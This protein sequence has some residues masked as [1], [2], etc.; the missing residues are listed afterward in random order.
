VR[1]PRGARPTDR[2]RHRGQAAEERHP[3]PGAHRS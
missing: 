1:G 3:R 2:V